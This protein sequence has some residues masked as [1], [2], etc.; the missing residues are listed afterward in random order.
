MSAPAIA[1]QA[2]LTSLPAWRALQAH[3]EKVHT[4]HLR[5]LFKGDPARGTRL[6]VEA[7]GIYFDYSKHRITD[8][9]VR[10]LLDL[11][12]QSGL[13]ERIEAMFTGEKINITENRAV[14]HTALRAPKGR[15][16]Q[17][18]RQERR[19]RACMKCSTAWPTSP[20]VC[21]AARGRDLPANACAM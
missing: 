21:A 11:A 12:A 17:S 13:R 6:A 10:L 8:E 9:T 3:Y 1:V 14:L 7:E 2:P 4:Q 18:G 19:A 16:D 20:T 5:D 15:D